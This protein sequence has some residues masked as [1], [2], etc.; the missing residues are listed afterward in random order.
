MKKLLLAAIFSI[1]GGHATAQDDETV[2]FYPKQACVDILFAFQNT[3]EYDEQ[4]LFTGT[5]IQY[6]IQ[7]N[8]YTS[9]M[10]FF[11]NQAS[12]TW[13]LLNTYDDGK[14]CLVNNGFGFEPYVGTQP[15]ER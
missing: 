10:F 14:T 6:D 12:G 3:R 7:G 2:Y 4:L 15:V 9:A 11:V 5:G 1:P 8:P 13:V